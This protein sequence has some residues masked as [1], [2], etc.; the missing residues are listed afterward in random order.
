MDPN[1]TKVDKLVLHHA[2]TPTWEE[3][4]RAELANWFSNNGFAR[5]YG[6]N[7][8]NWSGLINPYTGARSYSQAHFAGQRVDSR[9]PDATDEERA[10][11]YRLVQLVNDVWGQITWHAGNWAVNQSSIGIENL[12]DY[13]YMD[14]RENDMKVIADFWRGRDRELGG[15][16]AVYGH[17]EVSQTGTE[18]PASIMNARN[19]IVDLINAPDSG[20]IP[21]TP[22][23]PQN[24]TWELIPQVRLRLK[25]EGSLVNVVT[26]AVVKSYPAG[27]EFD[28]NSKTDWNGKTWYRTP[29]STNANVNNGFDFAL[30]EEISVTPPPVEP[31]PP[32]EPDPEPPVD[33]PE[34]PEEPEQPETPEVPSEPETPATDPLKE[35]KD[36]I[37]KL[38]MKI[39]DWIQKWL[40]KLTKRK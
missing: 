13:R 11:G 35:L 31:E 19:R 9:T 28:L 23:A 6:S 5:A 39:L 36:E 33:V 38:L 22:P 32:T 24:P 21:P 17:K 25:T 12:G 7:P 30:L 34:P 18:C 26:G 29:F 3:K 10:K 40:E 14:M 20:W 8:A 4:S 37:K 1:R 16:T 27:T 2:V 15:A